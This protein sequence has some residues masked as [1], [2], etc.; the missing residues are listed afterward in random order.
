MAISKFFAPLNGTNYVEQPYVD[1]IFDPLFNAEVRAYYDSLYGNSLPGRI[2]GTMS[3]YGQMWENALTG[4]KG[5]LGPG[6]GILGTFG[7]SMDK[8]DDF[9]LGGLTEGVNALGQY[10]GGNNQAPQNPIKNIF[11]NDYNYEGTKLMAAMGNAMAKLAGTQTPLDESD[12]QSL[13]DKVA[14]TTIDLATDP[15]IMGGQL[16]RLNGGKLSKEYQ[17]LKNLDKR[18]PVG[19]MG[20]ILNGYDDLMANVA[21]NMALPGLKHNIGKFYT[22]IADKLAANS[23]EDLVD[24]SWNMYTKEGTDPTQ[25]NSATADFTMNDTLTKMADDVAYTYN[26]NPVDDPEIYK[27]YENIKEQATLPEDVVKYQQQLADIE[28]KRQKA[29]TSFNES[30]QAWRDRASKEIMTAMDKDE[31]L[32]KYIK[33]KKFSIDSGDVEITP[34]IK[35]QYLVEQGMPFNEA[36][37][38][39]KDND[40]LY[41]FNDRES[42]IDYLKITEDDAE[43]LEKE[44]GIPI[45]DYAEEKVLKEFAENRAATFGHVRAP[46]V[47]SHSNINIESVPAQLDIIDSHMSKF[48]SE[49]PNGFRRSVFNKLFPELKLKNANETLDNLYSLAHGRVKN[50]EKFY[51]SLNFKEISEMYDVLEHKFI[52]AIINNESLLSKTK[53]GRA[54]LDLAYGLHDDLFKNITFAERTGLDDVVFNDESFNLTKEINTVFDSTGLDKNPED[55][56]HLAQTLK[57][58]GIEVNPALQ[59]SDP[60]EYARLTELLKTQYKP[61]KVYETSLS[62]PKLTDITKDLVTKPEN[63]DLVLYQYNTAKKKQAAAMNRTLEMYSKLPPADFASAVLTPRS[64]ADFKY[65]TALDETLSSFIKDWGLGGLPPDKWE[66]YIKRYGTPQQKSLFAQI[67]SANDKF[68]A[69]KVGTRYGLLE[70]EPVKQLT[71]RVKALKGK[72]TKEQIKHYQTLSDSKTTNIINKDQML[73]WLIEDRKGYVDI[74]L[75][76]SKKTVKAHYDSLKATLISNI[77]KVNSKAGDNVLVLIDKDVGGTRHLGYAFNTANKNI[78]DQVLKLKDLDLQDMIFKPGMNVDMPKEYEELDNYFNRVNEV[79][80]NLSTKLG[81]VQP[82]S[83]WIKHVGA[84]TP[85]ATKYWEAYDSNLDLDSEKLQSIIAEFDR[86]DFIK[87]GTFGTINYRRHTLGNINMYGDAYTNDLDLIH[88]ST[89]TKGMFNNTNT[90]TFTDMFLSKNFTLKDNFDSVDTLERCFKGAD[91]TQFHGNLQNLYIISPKYDDTGKLI[92][93]K[94]YGKDRASL[95]RAFKDE[96]AI[97]VPDFTVTMLDSACKKEVRFNNKI[98]AFINKYFTTPFKLGTLANPGFIVGNMEDAYFKQ[99]VTMSRKY[100]TSLTDE[101]TNVATSMREVIALNNAFEDKIMVKYREFL[102][103]DAAKKNDIFRKWTSDKVGMTADLVSKNP[104]ARAAFVTYL[105]EYF[106]SGTDR[107][108][109]RVYLFLSSYQDIGLNKFSKLKQGTTVKVDG[110]RDLDEVKKALQRNEYSSKSLHNRILYGNVNSQGGFDKLSDQGLINNWYSKT[111]LEGSNDVE[112]LMR[113]AT[114]LNEMKHKGYN[115]DELLKAL[116]LNPAEEAKLYEKFKVDVS[117]AMN[118]MNTANFNYDK[119]SELL[120]KASYILPFPTFYIKNIGYWADI[121]VNKP[122]IVDNTIS[123]HEGIWSG[124]DTKD[125]FTAE[126][127]GRGAIPV[128]QQFKHLTGI[129]KQSPYNSMFGA[130]NA[131][132]DFK[133]DI[134]YRT[135]PV[136]RPLTRHLQHREDVKYRPYSTNQYEKNIKAGDAQFSDLA[137]MFHQL[138]PYERF[139]NTYLRTPGK[140]AHNQWQMSD[141]LP[142]VFQPDFKK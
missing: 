6:M 33:D 68:I 76:L 27:I 13:G 25:Y 52:P 128:G 64:I 26:I 58:W 113:S 41:L 18:T 65:T 110:I 4:K 84:D 2:L 56:K 78:V 62:N 125:E 100:G 7:R 90:Q 107:D 94:Q 87:K 38:L 49:V 19:Q 79:T 83:G 130:F 124:K 129:A 115:H 85:E 136:A 66:P 117:N 72:F 40:P 16:S 98:S 108:I 92:G 22:Q 24:H 30:Q 61:Y 47:F 50:G 57:S 142:S 59:D 53:E 20:D 55:L 91:G 131:I 118:A 5:I 73:S 10:T 101:F 42:A 60:T 17:I 14:G 89:F 102:T 70:Y 51:K 12:F 8:A 48:L 119:S 32:K 105:N 9:I 43:E 123:F 11:V 88:T 82:D 132:N 103:S 31:V 44:F 1:D 122:Q 126:A 135:N 71:T 39:T 29:V 139:I 46:F 111:I 114:V 81:H 93:F 95:E 116:N 28:T 35:R 34:E 97:L 112:T 134:A 74:P 121:F 23:P 99:A 36:S 133:S 37:Y 140:V 54:Y 75:D 80:S 141:F 138:N 109:A 63:L 3:G 86:R 106:P 137:Y 69:N 77:N 15:G 96:H 120:N 127:K 104:E 21:G 45:E 67:T